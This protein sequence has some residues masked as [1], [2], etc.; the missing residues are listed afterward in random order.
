MAAAQSPVLWMPDI[1]GSGCNQAV[2]PEQ[3]PEAFTAMKF[4]AFVLTVYNLV[5]IVTSTSNN[6][7][8]NNNLNSNNFNGNIN[9]S[10]RLL[11]KNTVLFSFEILVSNELHPVEENFYVLFYVVCCPMLLLV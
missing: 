1:Q 10:G 2:T 11:Q 4:L 9:I 7:L 3:P 5:S 6:N 8:N